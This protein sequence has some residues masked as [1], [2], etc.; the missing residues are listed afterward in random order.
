[1]KF[2]KYSILAVVATSGLA[3]S[4]CSDDDNEY[5]PGPQSD[6]VYF[7]TTNSTRLMLPTDA[8]ALEISVARTGS[9]EAATYPVIVET[10][11]PEGL[12]NF[13]SEVSFAQGEMT[14]TYSAPCVLPEENEDRKYNLTL[15]FS[16]ETPVCQYGNTSFTATVTLLMKTEN[17][18]HYGVALVVDGWL[19]AIYSFSD[20]EG[21]TMTYE[22]L[23][24]AVNLN[25]S[26]ERPG[27]FQLEDVW[28]SEEAP[29]V[30]VGINQ[31]TATHENIII[32]ARDPE[33]VII[34]PQYSGVIWSNS[35]TNNKPAEC[36]IA[37][38][39][40]APLNLTGGEFV[41]T[42]EQ[43]INAG[44][45]DVL[46]DGTYLEINP[47]F[48]GFS[49]EEIT[50]DAYGSTNT[51][52]IIEFYPGESLEE[53][54]ALSTMKRV[55]KLRDAYQVARLKTQLGFRKL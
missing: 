13:P 7:A 22:D 2:L 16:P 45:N 46:E 29:L 54:Q 52:A 14:T 41:P 26:V 43:I 3:F 18:E 17:F 20:G 8:T 49:E 15:S 47:T 44:Y 40:G 19:T 39:A 36:Y 23:G 35:L 24:W 5:Q 27:V 21:T 51:P 11:L 42:K 10:D 50:S 37:N 28:T 4:A 30:I 31:N 25:Q 12:F 9:S 48:F 38:A 6:G 53:A 34:E 33:Y 55:Q 1:M 32:D